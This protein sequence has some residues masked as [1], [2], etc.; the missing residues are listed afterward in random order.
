MWNRYK[1]IIPITVYPSK[2]FYPIKWHGITDIEMH[3]KIDIPEESVMF[4]YGY[5]TNNLEDKI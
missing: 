4:Q 3:T 5:T 2:T 1:F